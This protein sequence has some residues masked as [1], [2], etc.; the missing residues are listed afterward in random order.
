MKST[1][2]RFL[3]GTEIEDSNDYQNHFCTSVM[4]L[5][6]HAENSHTFFHTLKIIDTIANTASIYSEHVRLIVEVER[7]DE[8]K[9]KVWLKIG[10]PNLIQFSKFFEE[11]IQTELQRLKD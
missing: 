5:P 6:Y 11:R 3:V 10:N 9:K 7:D 8:T 4:V 1:Y 2:F